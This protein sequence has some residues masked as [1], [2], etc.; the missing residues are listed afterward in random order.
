MSDSSFPPLLNNSLGCT[1]GVHKTH[2][3]NGADTAVVCFAEPFF[4]ALDDEAAMV[5][6][7]AL[8]DLVER[9][10][11]DASGAESSACFRWELEISVR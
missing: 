2:V 10:E 1:T 8:V 5:E 6:A 4:F 3:S 7:L 11:D 9:V